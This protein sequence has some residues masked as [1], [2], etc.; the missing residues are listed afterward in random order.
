MMR[1]SDLAWFGIILIGRSAAF[2][3]NPVRHGGLSLKPPQVGHLLPRASRLYELPDDT[4]ENDPDENNIVKDESS[5]P[6]AKWKPPQPV[7]QILEA[8]G[9]LWSYSVIFL[10]A[11]FSFGLILNL[12]G[13]AYTFSW[14]QGVRI[15]TIQQYRTEIQWKTEVQRMSHDDYRST[16]PR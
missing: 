16:M 11:V 7:L 14:P 15:D 12:C 8:V 10:G 13:Y 4:S 9:M 5:K 6:P 2:V 3:L 1:R